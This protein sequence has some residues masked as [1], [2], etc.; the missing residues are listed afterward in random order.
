M[1]NF[2]LQTV[3]KLQNGCASFIFFVI[4]L[5]ELEYKLPENI[6]FIGKYR[7]PINESYFP[8]NLWL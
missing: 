3:L 8:P 1:L 5:H 4:H 7:I 2:V 6:N